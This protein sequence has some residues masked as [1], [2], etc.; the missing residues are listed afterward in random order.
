MFNLI[1][2]LFNYFRSPAQ[3]NPNAAGPNPHA[4]IVGG[5]V[6]AVVPHV[7]PNPAFQADPRRKAEEEA[8]KGL[9]SQFGN[10]FNRI[11]N[12]KPQNRDDKAQFPGILQA[13]FNF[14]SFAGAESYRRWKNPEADPAKEA[15]MQK[16]WDI[17]KG[18]MQ[19]NF[20]LDLIKGV[21]G[22]FGGK[23]M[24]KINPFFD[25]ISGMLSDRSEMAFEQEV[26][27]GRMDADLLK[28]HKASQKLG[29]EQSAQIAKTGFSEL[30][31]IMRENSSRRPQSVVGNRRN[32]MLTGFKK[33]TPQQF[34]A[35]NAEDIV[36]KNKQVRE[37]IKAH[38]RARP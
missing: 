9:F 10:F 11:K 15:E 33:T 31:N 8:M 6:P 1:K 36:A 2:N 19:I 7:Q 37:K 14:F 13:F 26:A 29:R 16:L 34:V 35:A 23:L 20:A 24:A 17:Q 18:P 12:P 25:A 30:K 32:Q 5:P 22:I 3:N 28:K 21:L 4:P 38:K 27:E